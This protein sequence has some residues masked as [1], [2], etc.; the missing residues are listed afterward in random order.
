MN[1]KVE[2]LAPGGDFAKA[3][4]AIDFGADAI[5]LGG[6]QYSLRARASNFTLEDIAKI[7]A[8]AHA[9]KRK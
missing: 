5:Y 2:L 1:N 4:T 3:K 7:S 9:K 6:L 8:Y